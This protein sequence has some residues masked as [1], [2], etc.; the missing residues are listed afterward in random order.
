MAIK[1]VSNIADSAL[2]VTEGQCKLMAEHKACGYVL[3]DPYEFLVAT[4]ENAVE[5]IKIKEEA[6]L[7][8]SRM[9]ED[10]NEETM[11]G[12]LAT[13]PW[14]CIE[15]EGPPKGKV[16]GH[17]GRHRAAACIKA[18]ET[19]VPVFL[20]AM[21]HG[22][23]YNRLPVSANNPFSFRHVTA[24]DFPPEITGEY[25]PVTI[26]LPLETWTQIQQG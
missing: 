25:V 20:V 13:P 8:I 15:C 19:K 7:E 22:L 18:G 1:E 24:D 26:K 6:R 9:L 5:R 14:L 21:F 12:R 10:Y 4:T 11:Y 17:D 2:V 3:M 16:L 23:S